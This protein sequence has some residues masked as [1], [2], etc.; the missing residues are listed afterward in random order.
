MN[1]VF[2]NVFQDT[3]QLL[4]FDASSLEI[5]GTISFAD[6]SK[7]NMS[8]SSSDAAKKLKARAPNS[9]QLLVNSGSLQLGG[10]TIISLSGSDVKIG[11]G[12]FYHFIRHR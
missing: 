8:A 5:S 1:P 2:N 7:L 10:N 12:Q 11:G 4:I 9:P 3:S 6:N